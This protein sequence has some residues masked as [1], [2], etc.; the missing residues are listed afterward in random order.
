MA[1]IH[2]QAGI[3]IVEDEHLVVMSLRLLIEDDRRFFVTGHATRLS[4]VL[5]SIENAPPHLALVDI[6]LA[7]GESGLD[8][9]RALGTKH[10]PSLLMSGNPPQPPPRD[11]AIGCIAKPFGDRD[12]C[13]S[14]S[15]ALDRAANRPIP[16]TLPHCLQIY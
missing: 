15:I 12:M 14:L 9:A 2:N 7:N 5:S 4:E 3:L 1:S 13:T 10:I 16:P 8:V 6:R 11:V